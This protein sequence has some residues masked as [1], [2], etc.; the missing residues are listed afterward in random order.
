MTE[1]TGSWRRLRKSIGANP[2]RLAAGSAVLGTFCVLAA[3]RAGAYPPTAKAGTPLAA[4]RP[5]GSANDAR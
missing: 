5:E 2:G 3:R 4:R 1:Q